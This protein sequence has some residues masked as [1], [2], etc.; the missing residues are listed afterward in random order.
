MDPKHK[1]KQEQYQKLVQAHAPKVPV[2]RNIMW[3]FLIGGAI[4]VLGQVMLDIFTKIEATEG[5]AAATTLAA[6]IFFGAVATGFGVYDDLSEI[7]GAGAAVP[8]TGF[9]NTVVAAAMEFRR[10]GL[11]LGMGAKMFVIAGPVLVYGILAGFI[12]TLLRALAMGLF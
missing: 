7:A 8:I 6:M 11:I 10:E 5:E 9:A 4:C 12:V 1:A 3:A 2:W